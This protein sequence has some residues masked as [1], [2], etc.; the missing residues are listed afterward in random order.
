MTAIT[1]PISDERLEQLREMAQHAGV[2]AEEIAR[3]G[4]EDWLR[5][6]R[7]DFLDAAK[8]AIEKNAELYCRLA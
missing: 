3:A 8:K 6:P 5:Q 7:A 1:I 4:L 2:T